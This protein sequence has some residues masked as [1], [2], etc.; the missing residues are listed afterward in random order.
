MN[1]TLLGFIRKEFVQ[2]LRDKRMRILL[3]VAPVIQM[4]IFSLALTNEIRNVPIA[5]SASPQDTL[6]RRVHERCLSSGYFVPAS[7]RGEDPFEWVRSG[8]A[9]VALVAPS[10]GFTRAFNRGEGRLQALVDANNVLRAR[11]VEQYLS[12]LLA[13]EAAEQARSLPIPRSQELPGIRLD[14][15]VLYNPE[16]RSEVFMI[17]S[18]LCMILCIVTIIL[19]SMSMAR[20]KEL[21]TFETLIASPAKTWEIL[22]GKTLPFVVLGMIDVPLILGVAILGFG[23]PMRGS[24]L[25]LALASFVFVCTTVCIGVLISTLAKRQQ[26]AMMGGFMFLFP[27]LQLSGIF[28]PIEN[29]PEVLKIAAYVDPLM[30]FVTLLRNIMLKG[31]D[32]GVVA[33]NMS[34]LIVMAAA[35]MTAA[36]SRFKQTLD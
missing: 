11:G 5:L 8:Q 18:V 13:S 24:Y 4:T 28:F 27:A 21:G 16:M 15:R 30:Y 29:M 35:A 20:E 6:A 22:M 3:F 14:V 25:V 23:V 26:Q 36:F 12:V 2:T 34:V 33:L 32:F 10:G 7:V 9:A 31:G 19:T 17:P 1:D